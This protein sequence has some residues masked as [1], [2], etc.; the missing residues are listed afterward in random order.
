MASLVGHIFSVFKYTGLM[1][2]AQSMLCNSVIN[3]QQTKQTSDNC[4]VGV[5]PLSS[6]VLKLIHII[7]SLILAKRQN[8]HLETGVKQE[9]CHLPGCHGLDNDVVLDAGQINFDRPVLC[10]SGRC[11][12]RMC[13]AGK[14]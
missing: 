1:V 12:K 13:D 4:G 2:S 6:Q 11:P 7:T 14:D 8:F 9:C 3:M 10:D 5:F